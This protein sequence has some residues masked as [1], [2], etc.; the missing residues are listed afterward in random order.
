MRL[1]HDLLLLSRKKAK[2]ETKKMERRKKK[3]QARYIHTYPPHGGIFS[4]T[5]VRDIHILRITQENPT[6]ERKWYQNI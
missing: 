2:L 1:N 4:E 6:F 3:K 5:I